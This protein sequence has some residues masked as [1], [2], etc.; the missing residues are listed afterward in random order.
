MDYN[1]LLK[2]IFTLNFKSFRM[3]LHKLAAILKR[4]FVLPSH[5]FSSTKNS[6]GIPI[7]INNRNRVT[8]LKQLVDWL[9]K[10]GYSNIIIL[11]NDSKYEPLI[12]Y[13][14]QTKARVIYLKSNLVIW[15]YG[16]RVVTSNFIPTIMFIQIPMFFQ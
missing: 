4:K 13:Y 14:K 7:I 8:F 11:D 12:E 9:I 1:Q 16:N 15:P 6:Y 5:N 2:D 10:A 3:R